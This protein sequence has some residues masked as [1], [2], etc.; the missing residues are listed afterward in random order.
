MHKN[1]VKFEH[2]VLQICMW[3]DIHTDRQTDMLITILQST[4]KGIAISIHHHYTAMSATT[5][6]DN[7]AVI[8]WQNQQKFTTTKL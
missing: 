5:G 8:I 3:K 7:L 2:V 6:R 4:T 1:V